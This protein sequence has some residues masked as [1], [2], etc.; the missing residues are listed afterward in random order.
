MKSFGGA[1]QS[2]HYL[3]LKALPSLASADLT[4]QPSSLAHTAAYSPLH[5]PGYL[6][7]QGTPSPPALHVKL[8]ILS[9]LRILT[10][11]LPSLANQF[12]CLKPSLLVLSAFLH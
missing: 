2:P 10:L 1:P 4:A 12:F 11:C 8:V 3:A 9:D 7:M 5:S 6:R